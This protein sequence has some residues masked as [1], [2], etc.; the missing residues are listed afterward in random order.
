MSREKGQM[1]GWAFGL[2][3]TL[4]AL[5]AGLIGYADRQQKQLQ[6]G[7]F[8]PE[9]EQIYQLKGMEG[10]E[11]AYPFVLYDANGSGAE[12]EI[13]LEHFLPFRL[14]VNGTM[15]FEYN[16]EAGYRRIST[17]LLGPAEKGKLNVE[18][19][20]ERWTADARVYFS[21]AGALSRLSTMNMMYQAL[22]MGLLIGIA[23]YGIS[24]YLH[25][26]SEEYLMVFSVYT[27]M[28]MIW[29]FCQLESG[30]I[31]ISAD[32]FLTLRSFFSCLTILQS[33]HVCLTLMQLKLQERIG[34]FFSWTGSLI[35]S[36]SYM[37]LRLWQLSPGSL[38]SWVL[39]SVS[40]IM[41][42]YVCLHARKGQMAL[43]IGFSLT[44]LLRIFSFAADNSGFGD[45][46]L[47]AYFRTVPFFDIPF[48]LGCM[49][50]INA[51]FAGKFREAEELVCELDRKV[52]QRTEELREQQRQK[53]QL[54]LNIFHDL[55]SP[56][57]VL[58]GY[59]DLMPAESEDAKENLAVMKDR[60]AFLS[61]MTEDLFLLTK[62]EENKI[63]FCEDGVDLSQVLKGLAASWYPECEKRRISLKED[64][65]EEAFVIG[66][67]FRLEQA[68]QN[69]LTNAMHYTPDGGELGLSLAIEGEQILVRV[70]DHGPGIAEED[71][72]K[73]FQQYYYKDR[74]SKF[75]S[76][77]LGLSIALEIIRHH[78]G[79]I[80][81]E[82]ELGKGSVFT[83]RLPKW[84]AAQKSST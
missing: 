64:I 53:R 58:Q 29:G 11:G 7:D 5:A 39:F 38:F 84:Q 74:S 35:V 48:V 78:K 24:L 33:I 56:I 4:A 73:I 69:L 23:F 12:W 54:M 60:L 71:I 9:D 59:M 15:I 44:Q 6:N 8:L 25:K 40:G 80:G 14:W 62:L 10:G 51:R 68:F 36:F 49:M 32:L 45:T 26:S 1:K 42:I 81:V 47:F 28:L 82:S 66:D 50:A 76:T 21:R 22:G 37:L 27:L 17:V 72:P 79:T 63:L 20:T 52:E 46:V 16:G 77:G 3:L 19:E 70:E 13:S 34:G 75:A 43:V 55:R 61:H 57:F 41:V 30:I 65:A 67:R 18:I 83:V 31:R 2:V